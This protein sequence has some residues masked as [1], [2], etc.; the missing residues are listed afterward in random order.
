MADNNVTKLQAQIT[1]LLAIN[2]SHLAVKM[3]MGTTPSWL[4][5]M[6]GEMGR[7]TTSKDALAELVLVPAES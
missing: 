4:P 5:L 6:P 7:M 3:A 1:P 2:K